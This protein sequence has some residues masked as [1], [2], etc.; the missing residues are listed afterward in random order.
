D[1]PVRVPR[2]RARYP[3]F[4]DAHHTRGARDRRT[5]GV[6]L[7]HPLS[8]VGGARRMRV[9]IDVGG[10]NTDAVLLE[11]STVVGKVKT[12][13]TGDVTAGIVTAV[14]RLLSTGIDRS[15]VSSVMIGTTQFANAVIERRRLTPTAIVRLG[16]PATQSV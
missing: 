8:A 3:L 13:T 6:R 14:E 11:G 7:R 9:G 2:R 15:S 1:A 10:T 12:Q 4:A 16:L 5:A